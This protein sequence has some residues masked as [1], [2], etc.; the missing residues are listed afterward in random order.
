MRAFL[1]PP[2]LALLAVASAPAAHAQWATL[3]PLGTPRSGAAVA[4]YNGQIYVM[5]GRNASGQVLGSV[6]RYNPTTNTWSSGPS[7]R[8]DRT[9]AAATVIGGYLVLTGGRDDDGEVTDDC[10]MYDP[11]DNRWESYSNLRNEREGHAAFSVGGVGYAFGGSSPG[12]TYRTDAEVY[13]PSDGNW[14]DYNTW[15]LAIPRASFGSAPVGAG[16]LVVGGYSTFGPL[17]DVEF[18]VPGQGGTMRASLPSPRGGLGAA[19]VMTGAGARVYAVGGRNASG[20][21]LMTVDVFN[22]DA[23]NWTPGPALP[24]A[25]NMASVVSIGNRLYV[26]GG[27]DAAGYPVNT[28]YGLDV[29]TAGEAGPAAAAALALAPPEPNPTTGPVRVALTSAG[30]TARVEVYDALGR[31]VAVLHDGTLAAGVHTLDWDGRADG[32]APVPAGVYLVR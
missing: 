6:E 2:L 29:L 20:T 24:A 3:A 23:N 16:V 7:L 19:N 14:R 25:R 31:R 8:D 21:T 26:I 12:G 22:P 4:V 27:L 1:L 9:N 32:G 15:S 17:S 11:S 18:Y 28:V 13:E 10:E 5:G 30:G